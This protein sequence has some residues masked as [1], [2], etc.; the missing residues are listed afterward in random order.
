MQLPSP[1][2]RV[3][4][5]PYRQH[6]VAAVTTMF[7]DPHARRFYPKMISDDQSRQWISWNLDNYKTHGFG[8]W[9]IEDK[10]VGTFLG[11]CGLT[12]QPV[13]GEEV[14]EVGYHLQDRH[15]GQGYATEA[16]RACVAH[17]FGVLDTVSVC[18]IVD[19]DNSPSIQVASRMHQHHRD[20]IDSNGNMMLLYWTESG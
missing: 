5:R 10:E 8:L 15:R 16:G 2:A 14:L 13:D 18:S 20:F 12:Y 6:D 9:V 19:P 3:R 4:F 7:A 1:T 17:A 11:D